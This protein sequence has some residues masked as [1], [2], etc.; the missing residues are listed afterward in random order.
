MNTSTQTKN[1]TQNMSDP[2]ANKP[3]YKNTK[4]GWI[5][6]DWDVYKLSDLFTFRNGINADK[7]SYGKG[8]KFINVREVTESHYLTYE[9]IPGMVSLTNDKINN[10]LVIKG[11]ILFNRTSETLEEI[12]LTAVYLDNPKVVFGG[13]VI[14]AREKDRRID[15]AFKMYCFEE[16]KIRKQIISKGQGAVRANIG[17]NDLSKVIIAL[18]SFPEQQKIAQI[19]STWDRAIEKT[20]QLIEKK[21]LLKKGLMQQLFKGKMRFEKF[22]EGNELQKTKIGLIP[23]DW[24]TKKASEIFENISVK[25][26]DE[27]EELLSATQEYGV[28]PRNM[29][30]G[31]VTMPT[32]NLKSFKLVEKGDFVIS[33]R[34]FQGGIEHSYY[35]GLASPAYTVLKEKIEIN[36][37]F[38]RHLFKTKDFISRLASSVIGIRDGKQINYSDFRLIK[39]IYPPIEEQNKI[40]KIL[41]SLET[42]I[43]IWKSYSEKLKQQKKGLMQ[44]LLNG[45]IRVKT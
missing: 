17:Q 35:R 23:K 44:Q 22:K 11:D 1:Q 32:G 7:D 36:K 27:D 8:I 13:F 38:Y 6:E 31:K 34:T 28:I 45:R 25:N 20:E 33:L 43:E 41:N 14:R 2:N 4:L 29:L 30:E 42:E 16:P 15:N 9:M 18:P 21:Q 19:L 26:N 3:G 24:E 10:N 5:P 40:A 12:G 37:D 39:I